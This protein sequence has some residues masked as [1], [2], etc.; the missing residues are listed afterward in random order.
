M[1]RLSTNLQICLSLSSITISLLMLGKLIGLVPD[2]QSLESATRMA[3]VRTVASHTALAAQR[4]DEAGL[5]QI[6]QT[7]LGLIPELTACEYDGPPERVMVGELDLTR[8]TLDVPL[9]VRK[10][11]AATIRFQ[12]RQKTAGPWGL[13]FL[14]PF[15]RFAGL[16]VALQFALSWSYLRRVLHHLD[17]SRVVPERV[18]KTLDA[19][20]EGL[21][22]L[23]KD[24]RIVLANRAFSDTVGRAAKDLLGTSPSDLM[25]QGNS[26]TETGEMPWNESLREGRTRI[27]SVLRIS[28]EVQ[29]T[30]VFRVN[31]VP[32][33][34]ERGVCSGA[35]AS[36]DDVTA[37][38][39]RTV[40]LTKMLAKLKSSRDQIRRQNQQLHSLATRDPL[41]SAL[42]RRSFF[43][44]FEKRW[45]QAREEDTPLTCLILDVD[46]FKNINDAHGHATGDSVLKNV[47]NVLHRCVR[48][49]DVVCRYGG[50]EFCILMPQTS[51]EAGAISAERYRHELAAA[52]LGP[53]RITASFGVSSNV[54]GADSVQKMMDQADKA[55]YAAKRLGRNRVMRWDEIPQGLDFDVKLERLSPLD[56][57]R[58]ESPISFQ[59]V[60]ALTS[61]LASRDAAT[62]AHSRRVADLCVLTARN[63]MTLSECYIL[64]NAAL[65][66]DIGK[67]GVPDAILLK[68]GP[69]GDEEWRAMRAHDQIGV[70]IIRS[71]FACEALTGIVLYH[72][73]RYSGV[74]DDERVP[75]GSK[76]PLGAR[77]LTIAD[78]YDA[79][80][81]DRVYR[82]GFT[83]A[84]AFAELRRCAGGQF[85]PELVERFIKI[86][87]DTITSEVLD[88][89]GVSKSAALRLGVQIESLARAI[90][91][92]DID[93]L[94]RLTKTMKETAREF[95]VPKI[96]GVAD[97]LLTC[98]THDDE[99]VQTL[100]LTIELME[101]CRQTQRTHLV[102]LGQ[103][104]YSREPILPLE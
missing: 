63:L 84:E 13:G 81:S 55:L 72:H 26:E 39:E 59:I 35:M 20:A 54:F 93:A 48:G 91:A 4:K 95:E 21:I 38:E 86:V 50:E 100:R 11:K 66:H 88:T 94:R 96:A 92:E 49:S 68:P 78:A 62:A 2:Q 9:E 3:L 61:A 16:F 34:D 76:I 10:Q 42:N 98:M 45:E 37:L 15:G 25:W 103:P 23:D 24:E 18:T 87:S 60:T 89:S 29:G 57:S 69:L 40:A 5:K 46:H 12:F 32:L 56:E 75:R 17:P 71:T 36:F 44:I 67:I 104:E 6:L 80:V 97:E 22:V 73:V 1:P 79:M 47:V 83:Q 82:R 8:E 27:G 99:W 52:E 33:L 14:S 51:P 41:T 90:D 43:E 74:P 53:Q 85:D 30:R 64:E 102:T 7:S 77:I 28:D 19:L 58:Q 65:L 101:L 70:E 31:S